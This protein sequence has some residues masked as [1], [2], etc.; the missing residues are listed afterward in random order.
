V[1]YSSINGLAAH[2]GAAMND[3]TRDAL[4][5]MG[6]GAFFIA[7]AVYDFARGRMDGKLQHRWGFYYPVTIDGERQP[8]EFLIRVMIALVIGTGVFAYGCCKLVGIVGNL[9]TVVDIRDVELVSSLCTD[10]TIRPPRGLGAG[11]ILPAKTERRGSTGD[12]QNDAQTDPKCVQNG[13]KIA[14]NG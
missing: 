13:R 11:G 12:A 8:I 4:L 1:G 10:I 6:F 2:E 9:A 3:N 7:C 14:Q 5:I